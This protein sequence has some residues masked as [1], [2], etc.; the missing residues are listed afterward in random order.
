M[1][2]IFA[3]GLSKDISWHV[4]T[5][6]LIVLLLLV[7]CDNSS[8]EALGTLEWDRVNSRAIHSEV[9][10]EFFVKEGDVVSVGDVLLKLDSRK[11]KFVVDQL[12][13]ELQ[14]AIWQEKELI[15]GPRDEEI[16]E[17]R[18]RLASSE[19]DVV[20]TKL[21]LERQEDLIEGNFTSQELFDNAKNSYLNAMARKREREQTLAK[22]LAGTRIEQLN[23][24]RAKVQSITA[25]L[26]GAKLQLKEYE[27][28]ATRAGRVDSLPYK[29]GDRPL[30]GVIVCTLLSGEQP[31]ARVYVPEPRRNKIKLGEVLPLKIDGYEHS[32][33]AKVRI[34]Q[35]K[36]N[37]TPYFALTERDRS[38]LSYVAELDILGDEIKS[39]GSGVPVQLILE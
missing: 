30:A 37:F 39:L 33:N 17:T 4:M 22:L 23:Q 1:K 27:I 11:Q 18:A 21:A 38:Y 5:P 2:M 13:G 14:N 26:E 28:V 9:I 25:T 29:L 15:A 31:W 7:G 35:G 8:Q 16:E 24:A 10:V 20:T 19:A 3:N 6:S 34:I 36:A 12:E 32:F